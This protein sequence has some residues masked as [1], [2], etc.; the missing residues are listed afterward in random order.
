MILVKPI[1]IKPLFVYPQRYGRSRA[2]ILRTKEK[3]EEWNIIHY[4]CL[5]NENYSPAKFSSLFSERRVKGECGVENFFPLPLLNYDFVPSTNLETRIV[6]IFEKGLQTKQTNEE[7]LSSHSLTA[8]KI[9][10]WIV[11]KL[12]SP[13]EEL[14]GSVI[15]IGRVDSMGIWVSKRTILNCLKQNNWKVVVAGFKLNRLL[16]P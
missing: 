9:F 8:F 5:S 7:K 11:E 3:G 1:K 6:N 12:Q 2:R 16:T 4:S 10:I 15:C 14:S 13:P